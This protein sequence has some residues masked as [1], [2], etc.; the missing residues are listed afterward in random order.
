MNWMSRNVVLL[1]LALV[2]A[3]PTGLQL[4]ADSDTFVDV[5]RIPLM[6]QGFTSDN[7]GAVLLAL[8]KAEQSEPTAS[9]DPN[10]GPARIVYDE[11][12]LQLSDSTWRIGQIPGQAAGRLVGAP[13]QKARIESDVFHHLRMIRS[14]PD[15]LVV[16]N[17]TEEQLRKY[18]LDEAHAYLIRV[19]DKK[20]TNMLA[21]LYVGDDSSVGVSGTEAV[22]GVFVRQLGSNDVVLYE[23]EK[24]WRRNLEVDG[25]LDRVL[26]RIEPSQVRMLSINNLSTGGKP[27]VFAREPGKAMWFAK[28]PGEQLGA[29]RQTEIE[30]LI[31]RF[32]YLAVQGFEWSLKS[33]GNMQS[34]GLFPPA[35]EIVLTVDEGG[36]QREIQIAVGSKIDGRNDYYMTCSL[37]PFIMAWS[38]SMVTPFELDVAARL[39][40]PK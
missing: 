29:V 36:R 14:D 40:D 3:V 23:W 7:A 5:G 10:Q 33:A 27:F 12:L 9:Q 22:R 28:G 25:W 20:G 35:V 15:T 18:G 39:F 38:S 30:G 21:E 34:Y 2:L 8:P 13:V 4:A 37:Q 1:V 16:S 24:P 6:F 31:Q 17:A 11:L 26:D 19:F 32:R